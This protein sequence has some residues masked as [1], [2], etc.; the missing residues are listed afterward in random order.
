M[1]FRWLFSSLLS[2]LTL[3]VLTLPAEAARLLFWRFDANQNRLV[4]TTDQGVQPRAMLIYNPTR[5]V[6]DL[7]GTTLSQTSSSQPGGGA[8]REIRSGQFDQQTA[9]LV[10][11]LDPRYTVDPQQVQVRGETARQWVVEL[12]TPQLVSSSP[13]AATPP[14]TDST[15]TNNQVNAATV[16]GAATQLREI[17]AT[18]DGFFIRTSGTT[19]QITV[20]R[21]ANASQGRQIILN[22]ANAS[23]TPGLTAQM[24]PN[25]RYSVTR[26][27]VSQ[28][29]GSPPSVQVVLGLGADSPDWQ[30]TVS[31]LGG[32]ILLPVGVSISSIPDQ[33]PTTV[34]GPTTPPSSV[35]TAAQPIAV[36]PPQPTPTPPQ[37]TP[38]T[39]DL[40]TVPNGQI[41]VV[42]DPGHGGADPGAIGVGGLQEKVVVLSIATQVAEIL[43]QQG[44]DA[45]MT[46]SSDFEIDLDPRVQIAERADADLFVSIHANAINLSRPD[47]N[48]LETYYYSSSGYRLANIIHNAILR[49][50]PTQDRG[51]RQARFYVLRNT[52]MP[53]VLVETGFVTGATDARNLADPVWQRQMATAIA[54][55]VLEYIQQNF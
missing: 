7:P 20:Q 37:P 50:V 3:V 33:P 27:T 44:V 36:P 2:F 52:S 26:W 49:S 29:T 12:P 21:S 6:I 43:R 39:G 38:P 1:R 34:T 10:I 11:E 54:Q 5:I 51:V 31:N 24:L 28:A 48:G 53:S 9:R 55:G 32:I 35:E 17:V 15:S 40:P 16:T 45:I 42:I 14:T 8:I 30:P 4:F 19:P 23:I 47:V 22:I 13:V 41:R 46:R 25:N 18:R